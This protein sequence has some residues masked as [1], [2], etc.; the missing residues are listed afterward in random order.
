M[1]LW[2][3][4]A[5]RSDC[6]IR[7]FLFQW[8]V[9]CL[10]FGNKRFWSRSF[11]YQG[12]GLASGDEL[13]ASDAVTICVIFLLPQSLGKALSFL[14]RM[15]DFGEGVFQAM[16]HTLV[17]EAITLQYWLAEPRILMRRSCKYLGEAR[18]DTRGS[19]GRGD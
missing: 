19:C 7:D 12:G 4:D 15:F 3:K 14:V 16:S 11:L 1:K 13:L 5:G 18:P 10:K 2:N 6:G 8:L 9:F 17:I